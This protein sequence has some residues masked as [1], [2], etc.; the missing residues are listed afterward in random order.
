VLGLAVLAAT[1]ALSDSELLQTVAFLV[2]GLGPLALRRVR[3]SSAGALSPGGPPWW[4]YA[5]WLGT[6][7]AW[8]AFLYVLGP[9]IV[10]LGLWFWWWVAFYPPL[11]LFTWLSHWTLS[12]GLWRGSSDAPAAA[13]G[14]EGGQSPG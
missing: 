7:A 13:A 9:D 11:E 6:A 4:T 5:T 3:A 8:T 1:Y 10:S 12:R 14:G 2:L